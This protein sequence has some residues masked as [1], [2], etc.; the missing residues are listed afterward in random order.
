M[1]KNFKAWPKGW[2]R[3]LNYPDIPVF[4][5]L[6]QTAARVPD[7]IAIIFEGMELTFAE[8]KALS[9]RFA[10]ALAALGVRK[11]DRI[12]IHL[13]NC[14]QFAIAYYGILK[15][16]GIFTPLSPLLAPREVLYQLNDSGTETLI[17]LDTLFPGIA[18]IVEETGLKRIITTSIAD[19]LNAFNAS[20]EPLAK[21]EI[22]NTLDMVSL[23]QQYEPDVR[24]I[25]I[26]VRQD[27]AHLSYTGGT[28]GLSK[29]VMLTHRNVVPHNLNHE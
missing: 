23:L 29:F 20:L 12:A 8:L 28:T 15:I 7:R 6:D 4:A 27:L 14:P 10:T 11:G 18:S 17:S 13:P 16:G 26:D 21:I 9:E 19:C 5:F 1:A 22:P 25:S 3:S 2:P 24:K